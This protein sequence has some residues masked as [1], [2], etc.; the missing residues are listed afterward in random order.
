VL[1]A[2]DDIAPV[3]VFDGDEIV[4]LAVNQ[5]RAREIGG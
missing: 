5:Q 3:P 2:G 1:Q 4:A